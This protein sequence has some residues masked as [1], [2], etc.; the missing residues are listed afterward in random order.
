V[1]LTSIEVFARTNVIY[2]GIGAGG[3]ELADLHTAMNSAALAF[4]EPYEY[5]PHITLAQDITPE[6]VAETIALAR[7]RWE[8]YQ[9]PRAFRAERAVFV[10]NTIDNC[11]VDLAEYSLGAVAVR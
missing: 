7:L 8:E 4:V 9:G 6:R 2:I 11:W 1:E 3:S 5:H 10:Q